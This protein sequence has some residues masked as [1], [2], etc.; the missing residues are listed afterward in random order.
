MSSYDGLFPLQTTSSKA[1]TTPTCSS[2][3]LHLLQHIRTA[4][5]PPVC[6]LPDSYTWL[7]HITASTIP[8]AIL[9]TCPPPPLL[10]LYLPNILTSHCLKVKTTS[11]K[12][13]SF[14]SSYSCLLL[15]SR[16]TVNPKFPSKLPGQNIANWRTDTQTSPGIKLKVHVLIFKHP[17]LADVKKISLRKKLRSNC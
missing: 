16:S 15:W 13:T 17:T 12:Y 9:S 11:Y 14:T 4:C 6:S 3:N 8:K 2:Y 1:P 5:L 10:L 7:A